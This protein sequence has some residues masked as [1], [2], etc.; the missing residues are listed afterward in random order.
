EIK[1]I[2]AYLRVL[3][4]PDDDVNLLRII[5]TPRRGIGKTSLQKI[6]AIAEQKGYSLY[7]TISSLRWSEESPHGTRVKE[8]LE[9]FVG[10]IEYYR[11]TIL[12]G[13]NMAE[14]V[15]SMVE[16]IDY[17]GHLLQ[18][19]STN[20]NAARWKY[21]NIKT[22]LDLFARWEKD[23]DNLNP[24]IYTYLNKISLITRDDDDEG[25]S[26]KVHL[27]TI[28]A[29]K[30]LE[31]EIVF[32]AGV[33]SHLIPHARSVEENPDNLEEERRL[34]YV[35]I[36]R[37]KQKLYLTSC[38]TRKVLREKSECSPSPFLEEIPPE[39]I[40]FHEPDNDISA[41][42]AEDFFAAMKARVRSGT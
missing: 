25:V 11:E 8:S 37:A 2:I 3:A 22:F 14:T 17:W 33:E 24:N 36:T 4:N 27:M 23:P 39:L 18:E 28:H 1:D 6:R 16:R 5:N 32:L 10:L 20:D 9:E 31:F 7:S 38:R 12:S 34:F 41:E 30:G 29:S 15:S 21:K 35:A 19:H 26:G 42:D 40:E 13:K